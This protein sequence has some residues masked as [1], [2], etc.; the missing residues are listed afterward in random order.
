MTLRTSWIVLPLAL[1]L[2]LPAGFVMGQGRS[3]DIEEAK[4]LLEQNPVTENRLR[5]GTLQYLEGSDILQAGDV[6][7]AVEAMRSAVVTFEDGRGNPAETRAEFQEARYG[8]AYA[9]LQDDNP[10]EAI[11]VLNQLVQANPNYGKGAYLLGVTKLQ[12]PGQDNLEGG[13]DV[14]GQLARS[15]GAPYNGRAGRTATRYVYNVSTL[16]HA[17]GKPDMAASIISTLEG[18]IGAGMGSGGDEN[19]MI[20]FATGVY[21]FDNADT[22]GAIES[23]EALHG[24]NSG[25]SLRSGVSVRDALANSFYRA[26]REQLQTGGKSGGEL[27][28]EMFDKA[29][30]LGD[31]NSIDILHGRAAAYAISGNAEAAR[32]ETEK[33]KGMNPEYYEKIIKIIEDQ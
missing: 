4:K 17:N 14:L 20:A 16:P 31:S 25:F 12:Q 8:L 7:M 2:L 1:A 26:G 30:E 27:A 23:F 15:G 6:A 29:G 28:L 22:I 33:I 32:E 21:R 19:D 13:L 9:L 24:K 11:L 5:L 10:H 18:A 3:A